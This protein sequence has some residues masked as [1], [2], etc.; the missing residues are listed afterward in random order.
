MTKSLNWFA[1]NGQ[2]LSDVVKQPGLSELYIYNEVEYGLNIE[3]ELVDIINNNNI[4]VN[5]LTGGFNL[6]WPKSNLIGQG[7]DPSLVYVE[8]WPTFWF[9]AADFYMR[10]ADNKFHIKELW[11]EKF[12]YPFLT[13]NGRTRHHRTVLIDTL[14]KYNLI[15]Q[16]IVTYHSAEQVEHWKYHDGSVLTIDDTFTTRKESYD[17]NEKFV[18]SFLHIVGETSVDAPLLSEKTATPMMMKLPFLTIACPKFHTGYLKHMGFELY[19]EIFDYSFDL[20]NNI[21][22][23]IEMLID[24]VHKV[25]NGDVDQMYQVIKPKIDH[26]YNLIKTFLN[27]NS[28]I[29]SIAMRRMNTELSPYFMFKHYMENRYDS[30]TDEI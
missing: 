21:D 19:D 28:L 10:Q 7:I 18:K 26:N 1:W 29:P 14:A 9:K 8:A 15:N 27:D 30:T 6:H 13:F 20:E 23:K 11:P 24:N 22:T 4:K 25:V 17:F 16:G 5:L 2:E 3:K 12:D